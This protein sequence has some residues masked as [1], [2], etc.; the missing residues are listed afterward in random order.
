MLETIS[1]YTG[2]TTENPTYKQVGTNRTGHYEAVKITYDPKKISYKQLLHIFWYSV[3]PTDDGGQFCDRGESYRPAIFVETEAERAAAEASLREVQ[4]QFG[5][6]QVVVP[7]LPRAEFFTV[8]EGHQDYYL[9]N[10]LRYRY[11][12]FGCGRDKRSGGGGSGVGGCGDRAW[13]RRRL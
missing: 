3:D 11:Y 8:E 2:G 7:I 9:K 10:P 1:G 6:R 12:R 13:Y 5:R 4:A